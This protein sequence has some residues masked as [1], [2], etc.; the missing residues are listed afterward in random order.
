MVRIFGLIVALAALMAPAQAALLTYSFD[1][2][3][4]GAVSPAAAGTAANFAGNGGVDAANSRWATSGLSNG[5]INT[6]SFT[7][8]SPGVA[9]SDLVVNARRGS[10]P[11][12]AQIELFYN[13][14]ATDQGV[15]GTF[16]GTNTISTTSTPFTYNVGVN[17]LAGEKIN[18]T[19]R[20]TKF[21]SFT[22]VAL[23]DDVTL[24]G[25]VV[26]EPTSMA[27]FGLLGAGI[28]ARRIRRKA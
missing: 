12:G 24:D 21:G 4:S 7:A 5:R 25:N 13:V 20:S 23:F 22:G 28:A 3:A 8:G 19:I 11:N 14:G 27:V 1:S 16:L 10:G 18:F 9:I 17:L 26:P 15:N 2:D 6:F